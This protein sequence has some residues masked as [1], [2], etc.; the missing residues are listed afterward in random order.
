MRLDGVRKQQK[1][2][3]RA[4]GTEDRAYLAVLREQLAGVEGHVDFVL[5]QA[6]GAIGSGLWGLRSHVDDRVVELVEL[7]GCVCQMGGSRLRG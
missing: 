6:V 5:A 3:G 1:G 7:K 4:G 2:K